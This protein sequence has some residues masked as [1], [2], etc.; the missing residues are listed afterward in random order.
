MTWILNNPRRFLALAVGTILLLAV[1][2][3]LSLARPVATGYAAKQLCSGVAVSGLPEQWLVQEMILPALA[4]VSS[5]I[6]V[7]YDHEQNAAF[8][9]LLGYTAKAQY[10]GAQGC[11]LVHSDTPAR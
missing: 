3:Y 6:S 2:I 1:F 5:L 8:A 11:G 10:R 9:S 4:P 7:H